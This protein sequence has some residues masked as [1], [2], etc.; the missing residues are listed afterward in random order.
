MWESG[1]GEAFVARNPAVKAISGPNRAWR[2]INTHL[3]KVAHLVVIKSAEHTRH[4]HKHIISTKT[5]VVIAVR[6]N[7]CLLS[8]RRERA[9][10]VGAH[11]TS[12]SVAIRCGVNGERRRRIQRVGGESIRWGVAVKPGLGYAG[13]GTVTVV[14]ERIARSVPVAEAINTVCRE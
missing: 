8:L 5:S 7:R 9:L 1:V 4:A 14:G 12:N 11:L 10:G 3:V 13:L 6:A 2:M